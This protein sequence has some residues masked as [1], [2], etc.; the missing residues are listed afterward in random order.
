MKSENWK[1]LKSKAMIEDHIT[2]LT[3][4]CMYVCGRGMVCGMQ[5]KKE[6][7][8]FRID[9]WSEGWPRQKNRRIQPPAWWHVKPVTQRTHHTPAL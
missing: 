3:I 4:V 9:S 7:W 5:V 6:G 2:D 1:I 8:V